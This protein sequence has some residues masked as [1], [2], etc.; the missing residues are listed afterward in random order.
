MDLPDFLLLCAFVQLVRLASKG[1]ESQYAVAA[2]AFEHILHAFA[3]YFRLC[4]VSLVSPWLLQALQIESDTISVLAAQTLIRPYPSSDLVD[5]VV[6]R[7]RTV[8]SHGSSLGWRCCFEQK[9]A[10][11]IV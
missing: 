2:I 4:S 9:V 11:I 10:L 8:S 1:Q 6:N 3:Q 5:S 7:H